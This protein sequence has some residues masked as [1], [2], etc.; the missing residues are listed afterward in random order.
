MT[1]TNTLHAMIGRTF[2]SVQN[3]DNAELVFTASDGDVFRFYHNQECC[4]IVLIEDI[5]GDLDDLVGSPVTQAEEVV[6]EQEAEPKPS[7]CSDSWLWT[8]YKF[9]TVKGSV[10]VRWLGESNGYYSESVDLEIKCPGEEKT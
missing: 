7:D 1:E 6:S 8:F 5:C 3:V 2:I 4:E 9:A 10:T